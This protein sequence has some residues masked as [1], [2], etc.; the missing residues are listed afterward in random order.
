MSYN[1]EI[2]WGIPQDLKTLEWFERTGRQAEER[3]KVEGGGESACRIKVT[4]SIAFV[5]I[6]TLYDLDGLLQEQRAKMSIAV[7][8]IKA[9]AG[10]LA[11]NDLGKTRY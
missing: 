10:G 1:I 5:Y 4:K 3:G 7:I 2:A 11:W 8:R 9:G 6:G